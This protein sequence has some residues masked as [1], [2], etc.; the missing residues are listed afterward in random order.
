MGP[1]LSRTAFE[2]F[3]SLVEVP[4]LP[5][6]FVRGIPAYTYDYGWDGKTYLLAQGQ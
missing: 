6:P 2:R 3:R 1:P 5:D 4:V